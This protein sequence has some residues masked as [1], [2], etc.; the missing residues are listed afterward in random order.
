MRDW[1]ASGRSPAAPSRRVRCAKSGWRRGSASKSRHPQGVIAALAAG[2][3]SGRRVAVQLYPDA[4]ATLAD[5]L[6]DAGA[7]ADAV[8]PYAYVP[9]AADDRI[10]ALIEAMAAGG[11]DAIAFTSAAQ[12]GRLFDAARAAGLEGKLRD[13]LRLTM[14]AAVGPV[15]AGELERR[16]LPVAIMPRD[17]FFMKP[18]VSAII[19]ALPGH[20]LASDR[21]IAEHGTSTE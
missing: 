20:A 3:L 1:A 19:A 13:A 9:A 4:P 17:A 8:Q 18:L 12:V 21:R 11:I 14:I 2:G 5:F 10:R 15:V 7:Q 16:G 6:R